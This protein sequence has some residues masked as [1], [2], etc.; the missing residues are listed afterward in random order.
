MIPRFPPVWGVRECATSTV[1]ACADMGMGPGGGGVPLRVHCG[2]GRR[3]R[4][5]C[6]PRVRLR[7]CGCRCA[8]RSGAA[9]GWMLRVRLDGHRRARPQDVRIVRL[10]CRMRRLKRGGDP[11]PPTASS[12][13]PD[14]QSQCRGP[15]CVHATQAFPPQQVPPSLQL[16]AKASVPPHPLQFPVRRAFPSLPDA[17][18]PSERGI[19]SAGT[20]CARVLRYGQVQP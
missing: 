3:L 6:R 18:Q 12:Q 2:C 9:A 16:A 11:V 8:P 17:R 13:E 7:A 20:P 19:C 10:H 1:A 14:V 4:H 15:S 5:Y